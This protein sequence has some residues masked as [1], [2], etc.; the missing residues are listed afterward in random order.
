MKTMQPKI[1]CSAT[2]K[3][4]AFE[5]RAIPIDRRRIIHFINK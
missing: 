1:D 5:F 2:G 3:A 4:N